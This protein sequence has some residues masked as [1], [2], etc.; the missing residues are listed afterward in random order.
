[1]D[2]WLLHVFITAVWICI[3]AFYKHLS[4]YCCTLVG[5]SLSLQLH[6]Y[7]LKWGALPEHV[8]TEHRCAGELHSGYMHGILPTLKE[9]KGKGGDL[10]P[11]LFARLC[12]METKRK[13]WQLLSK[14]HYSQTQMDKRLFCL[15][16]MQTRGTSEFRKVSA[17]L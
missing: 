6:I 4:N 1:M 7:C 11:F 3:N 10:S 16:Y 17:A 2:T 14:S 15:Q 12:C 8:Q 9:R 13:K 5:I